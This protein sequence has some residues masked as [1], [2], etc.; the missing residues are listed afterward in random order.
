[1]NRK[2]F[3]VVAV[4]L[5]ISVTACIFTV[6][7]KYET[8]YTGMGTVI[9]VKLT[10]KHTQ[11][12]ADELSRLFD[13]LESSLD[14]NSTDSAVAR[15]NSLGYSD[16]VYLCELY[17]KSVPVKNASDGAF[18]FTLGTLTKLWN[19]GF[20]NETVPSMESIENAL[21]KTGDVVF[22]Q[23]TLSKTGDICLDFGGSAKGYACD[24]AGEILKN[25]S[26]T[27]AVI[28]VGGSLL[29]W[30]DKT[31]TVAVKDPFDT[32]SYAGTFTVNSCFVSTSGSY[33]RYFEYNGKKYHHLLDPITGFPK[34]TDLVSVTVI[35]PEGTVSDALSTACFILGEEESLPLLEKFASSAIFIYGDKTFSVVG[36][37][38]FT[39][40]GEYI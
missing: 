13:S 4:I 27:S 35:S 36:D 38:N 18:D 23:G 14:A 33:E 25:H 8:A 6:P 29:F 9:S 39:P 7:E 26:I 31:F 40:M 10:G 11:E 32:S 17:E 37:V 1:M 20:G 34:E 3:L 5:L 22:S 15:F 16:D 24:K 21:L 19:I 2:I 12:T 28:S 30:G